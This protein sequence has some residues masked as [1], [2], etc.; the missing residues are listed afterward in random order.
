MNKNAFEDDSKLTVLKNS[1]HSKAYSCNGVAAL[2]NA[3]WPT[4]YI[5]L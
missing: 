4:A 5:G 1:S 2:A 3:S